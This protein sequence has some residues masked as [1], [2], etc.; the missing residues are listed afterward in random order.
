MDYSPPGPSVHGIFQAT[1]LE[2][3]AIVFL[4]GSLIQ[5]MVHGVKEITNSDHGS[6]SALLSN[7]IMGD[8][9]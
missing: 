5:L 6:F 3:V 1:V 4:N 2:W 7:S 9:K 8:A